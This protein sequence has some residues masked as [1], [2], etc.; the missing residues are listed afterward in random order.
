[1]KASITG[2]R[3]IITTPKGRKP[4]SKLKVSNK[5]S[6]KPPAGK[7]HVMWVK[8]KKKPATKTRYSTAKR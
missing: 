6:M 7:E 8:T 4:T 1:M 2:N 5:W 3:K